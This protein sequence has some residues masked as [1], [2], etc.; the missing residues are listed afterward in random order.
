[1]WFAP[2][3]G[4]G[5]G[6][7]HE[8]VWG[9]AGSNGGGIDVINSTRGVSGVDV[10]GDAVGNVVGVDVVGGNAAATFLRQRHWTSCR[11]RGDGAGVCGVV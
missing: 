10:V 9:D 8:V 4:W 2:C 1:M 11:D 3:W 5:V 7:V 6:A